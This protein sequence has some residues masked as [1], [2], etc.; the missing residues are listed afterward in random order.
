MCL[1]AERQSNLKSDREIIGYVVMYRPS[2][3]TPGIPE[4]KDETKFH[5]TFGYEKE[6]YFL[7]KW[8]KAK[9]IP[10]KRT[11]YLSTDIPGFH[12]FRSEKDAVRC[13]DSTQVVVKAKFK[14]VIAN[15]KHKGVRAFRAMHRCLLEVVYDPKKDGEGRYYRV[16][17]TYNDG[18]RSG[19]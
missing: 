1:E 17:S 12:A 15:G 13:M 19:Y 14:G 9:K 18:T 4:S 11:I 3:W 2:R 10:S 7:N 8:Y 16:C 6:V 5:A